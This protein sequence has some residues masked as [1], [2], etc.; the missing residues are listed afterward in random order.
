MPVTLESLKKS[1][2]K[3]NANSMVF[4]WLADLEREAGNLDSALQRVDGGLTLYPN[5]IAAR[6]VRSKI[7]MQQEAYEPCVQECE[8]ILV[9]DP[10]NLA[11]QRIMGDAYD[12]LGNEAN[13]N[14]CYR[15]LHD[16][17][18][19]NTFW[20]E[21][22][23]VVLDEP[24]AEMGA[25]LGAG[26]SLSDSPSDLDFTLTDADTAA[27]QDLSF[28][29]VQDQQSELAE[30]D[31]KSAEP[32]DDFATISEEAAPDQDD[33]FASLA[34]MLP[35]GDSA[36]DSA[37]E[38]LS[39]SLDSAMD[40]ITSE[41]TDELPTEEFGGEENISGSDVGSA[42]SDMFGLE[43]DLEAEESTGNVSPFSAPAAPEA[44]IPASIDDK[45]QSNAESVFSTPVADKPQSIDDAFGDIFGEDELPEEKPQT[46][47]AAEDASIESVGSAPGED[48]QPAEE[49]GLF[50]KSAEFET[51]APA[52][53]KPQSIDDAFGDIFGE[54]ELPEEKPQTVEPA[55]ELAAA[56]PA[57]EP[58]A[59][60][61]ADLA[62]PIADLAEP[63]ADDF[64][65]DS[66]DDS[67]S[68]GTADESA[69]DSIGDLEM[70]A[71]DG[72]LFE[73][74]ADADMNLTDGTAE[75][76]SEDEK[77]D[78]ETLADLNAWTP[79]P[80][81]EEPAPADDIPTT[82]DNAFGSIF[83]EDDLPTED[84]SLFEKS[85]SAEENL[86][87][88]SLELPEEPVVSAEESAASVEEPV[89]PA[90]EPVADLNEPAEV[91]EQPTVE[92]APEVSAPAA[93]KGF[94]VDSAFDSL[95][96]SDD[97]LPEEK[98]AEE[99][100][101]PAETAEESVSLADQ[102]SQAE[103]ELE[104]P[105]T[106]PESSDLAKEMGGAFASMFGNVDDDLDL[107][108]TP[109]QSAEPDAAVEPEAPIAEDISA[110]AEEDEISKDLDD[111]FD[112]LFGKDDDL[113]L[114]SED[115]P[116]E[117]VVAP[118][119]E[120]AP[121]AAEPASDLDSL[122]SEVS[123]AFKGLFDMDDD[124][125]SEESKPSNKGVDFLMSG[126]SDDEI[127]AGLINNPDAPLDRGATDLDES[128]NTRTLAE[129]YFDQG[130]YAKALEIYKDLAQKE[131]ENEEIA[132]R[133][134][135]V[136]KLYNDKFGG[137][138]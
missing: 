75:V 15:R 30:T 124:S 12:K 29:D 94:S 84:S 64:S 126:D 80:A 8:K 33:P 132:K 119:A 136:E 96:G 37:M 121:T 77:L 24:A 22:Y 62:E 85:A 50:E 74:S 92:A 36:D 76:S 2:G 31:E 113:A 81:H 71:E 26:L 127:S 104:L 13:R 56:E 5:D 91:E 18:P 103:E 138:A 118:E 111:S 21:E 137:E 95:F 51:A 25:A 72:G 46:A 17:D 55:D 133:L 3:K 69:Q 93:D 70:P 43:D 120:A 49:G 57:T 38:D 4:A 98:P 68:L 32:V 89:A 79:G 90:E 53:D 34:A 61:A 123:G 41:S 11:A 109:A 9:M 58:A 128:L 125:L 66:A 54:D 16:M 48:E 107:P 35:N 97:D 88:E 112:S 114:P 129:I 106:K 23:D 102:V 10:F 105:E 135:E 59:E 86:S 131:P 19:L 67:L 63:A 28:D 117:S 60:P 116:S 100:V 45:A 115:A 101:A 52:A 7:L 82:V 110:K 108:E 20:K 39:A 99:N 6:L 78:S 1:V 122:E 27:P 130:L 73:K 83:G 47:P 14:R 134:A 65:L 40:S 44:D 42:L 87:A